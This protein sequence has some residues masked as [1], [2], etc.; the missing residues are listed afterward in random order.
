MIDPVRTL[1]CRMRRAALLLVLLAAPAVAD[2]NIWKD[3][4]GKQWFYRNTSSS[5]EIIA[6]TWWEADLKPG[7]TYEISFEVTKLTGVISLYIGNRDKV[8]IN[9]TGTYTFDFPV[10]DGGPRRMVFIAQRSDMLSAAKEIIVVEKDGGSGGGSSGGGSSGGGSSSGNAMPKGHY[11][12]FSRERNIEQEMLNYIDNPNSAP[13]SW[14]LNIAR[15]MHDAL[16][17]RAVKG[18]SVHIPWRDLETGDNQIKW[19]TLDANMRVARRLNK[20]FIVKIGTR[21]FSNDNPAP[22]YFPS[23]QSVWNGNG[24]TVKLW[25]SWA[26]NRLIRLHKRIID[27]YGSD[28]AFGGIATT[29]TSVGNVTGGNYTLSSYR[30][31]LKQIANQTQT[32]LREGGNGRFFWYLNFVKGGDSAN[33]RQDVRVDLL[34]NDVAHNA[35]A[36]GGPDITP[37]ARG[38]PSSVNSYRIHVRK[39]MSDVDQFCH[40]QHVDH[41][42]GGKNVKSNQFRIEYQ[43]RVDSWRH[44]ESQPWFNGTP[45]I[46]EFSDLATSRGGPVELHPDWVLGQLW[47]PSEIFDFANRNFHCDYVFWNYRENVHNNQTE[48]W[49]EDVQPIIRNNEY[50]YNR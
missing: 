17:M 8:T 41:G 24:F 43:E 4:F 21:G 23:H 2:A 20:K 50:F 25:D 38:M 3:S 12:N 47:H 5:G 10:V 1:L 46:F 11:L 35:L 45:A 6:G 32:A 14:H 33:M 19:S 7:N 29:E 40:L 39:T 34:K 31:A 28:S 30:N 9:S 15:D 36:I 13:S 44:R 48:Y 16:T 37:D 27:R 18:F 42:R 49:W 26:Y 22:N